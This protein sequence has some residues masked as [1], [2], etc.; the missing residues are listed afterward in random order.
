MFVLPATQVGIYVL[1]WLAG[2]LFRLHYIPQVSFAR[3][4]NYVEV[5]FKNLRGHEHVDGIVPGCVVSSDRQ[6]VH[7]H[8]DTLP[9]FKGE[10]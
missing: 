9:I 1:D 7:I 10:T 6:T 2:M 8:T 4:G 3:L 5:T